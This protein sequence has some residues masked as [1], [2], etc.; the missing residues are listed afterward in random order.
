LS[1]L[2]ESGEDAALV[3]AFIIVLAAVDVFRTKL[4]HAVDEASELMGGG[5]DGLGGTEPGFHAA[6]GGG[7]GGGGGVKGKG[8]GGG[9][10]GR[11]GRRRRAGWPRVWC[12]R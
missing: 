7:G 1:A 6:G 8:G 11:G 2:R 9:G 10:R 12:G 5:G 3:A 4:E